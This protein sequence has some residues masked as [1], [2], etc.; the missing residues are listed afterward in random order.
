M[1]GVLILPFTIL[2][3]A[4]AA[5]IAHKIQWKENLFYI[6]FFVAMMSLAIIEARHAANM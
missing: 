2:I 1:S 5:N 3:F 4:F 6:L